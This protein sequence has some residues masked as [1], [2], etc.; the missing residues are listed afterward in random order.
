V[1]RLGK[2]WLAT[3]TSAGL[4]ALGLSAGQASA[5]QTALTQESGPFW[6]GNLFSMNN[7]DFEN[8]TGDWVKGSDVSTLTTEVS[9]V[10]LHKYGLEIV[11]SGPGT[12]IINLTGTS[13]V[14]IDLPGSG[15]R[16]FRVGAYINMQ[17]SNSHTVE[18]DLHC[19]DSSGN[20]VSGGNGTQVS[21]VSDGNWHWV[22]NDILVPSDCAYVQDS[23]QL[24][25][26][27]MHAGGTIYMDEAWFAPERA[28]LMIG[29]YAPNVSAWQ[30]DDNTSTGI[31]PL[32]S[33][34][35]F[36][37]GN[38][39]VLPSQWQDTTNQCWE[40]TQGTSAP[41]KPPACVINLNPPLNSSNKPLYSESQIQ[42]FLTGLPA[43]QTVIMVYHG[44]AENTASGAFSGCGGT[45][46]AAEFVNCFA[47]EATNIRTAAVNLMLTEHVFTADDSASSAYVDGGT[48]VGCNWIVPPSYADFYFQDHY[49][50]GW[51]DGS[52]LSEQS[53]SSKGAQQ[54][55][56]W[57]SCVDTQANTDYKPIGLAE[58]GLCSGSPGQDICSQGLSCGTG[59][60]QGPSTTADKATMAADNTYLASEPS[61]LASGPGVGSPTLLWEY[62][63]DKCWQFDNSNHVIDEWQSIENQ[64]GGAVGG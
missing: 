6:P 64:S 53:S 30:S 55:N 63:Y 39:P 28:A 42:K 34:K 60:D 18:F 45:S 48:G 52:N 41:P 9:T 29:A 27:N 13:G 5:A 33:D 62:W 51:A 19:Y 54:W 31:G 2:R 35:V 4:I 56:N 26:T 58:Y 22:E 36:F 32:Q 16:T 57:L 50:R 46:D 61:T 49:E 11:A 25:F 14:K 3:I 47:D 17:S 10:F 37:G 20:P 40:I 7:A 43:N 38:S 8:G 23:P 59:T 12:S 1:H 24:Q 15:S 44:E 21:L